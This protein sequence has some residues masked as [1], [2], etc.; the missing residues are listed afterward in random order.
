MHAQQHELRRLVFAP[1]YLHEA[2][3]I[4]ADLQQGQTRHRNL[5]STTR[6]QGAHVT[7]LL[8]VAG[9]QAAERVVV[10]DEHAAALELL[11]MI[12]GV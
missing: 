1:G 7:D 3:V 9:L 12:L 2:H 5:R 10:R 8:R 4:V 11:S 6:I